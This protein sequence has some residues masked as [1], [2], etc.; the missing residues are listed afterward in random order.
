MGKFI[1]FI[2]RVRFTY[3]IFFNKPKL[4]AI[5]PD[6]KL[7]EGED[8]MKNIHHTVNPPVR[9]ELNN[10]FHLMNISTHKLNK[11]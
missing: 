10:W 8:P 2:G 9:P 3:S 6:K 4:E 1:K 5:P 11:R 7:F